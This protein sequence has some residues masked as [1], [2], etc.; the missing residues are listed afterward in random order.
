MESCKTSA[1]V[2][3]SVERV[4]VRILNNCIYLKVPGSNPGRS[5]K[6]NFILL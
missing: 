5:D 2:A 6:F 3:Q 4:A 1:S